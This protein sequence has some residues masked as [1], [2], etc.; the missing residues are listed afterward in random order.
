M[1]Q[2]EHCIGKHYF[3]RQIDEE[4]DEDN[5]DDENDE[6]EDEEDKMKEV[7][8]QA[9]NKKASSAR[10]T[11]KLVRKKW[12]KIRAIVPANE[13]PM[14]SVAAGG[15]AHSGP[16]SAHVQIYAQLFHVA[17]RFAG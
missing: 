14:V 9:G 11:L 7:K 12:K 3:S 16:S 2:I 6:E 5:Q 15:S 1:S 4:A 17:R 13:T 8:G 10:K